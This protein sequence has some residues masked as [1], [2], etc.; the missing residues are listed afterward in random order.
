MEYLLPDEDTLKIMAAEYEKLK[1]YS[2]TASALSA[3]SD[4]YALSSEKNTRSLHTY[5]DT[6]VLY[7][8]LLLGY[9]LGYGAAISNA[10]R[11]MGGVQ[12]CQGPDRDLDNFFFR[13]R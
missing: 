11:G 12:S 8:A 1:Q 13:K 4:N 3:E 5:P 10:D 7:F 2:N 6:L 9:N